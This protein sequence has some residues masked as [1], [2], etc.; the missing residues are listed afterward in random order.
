MASH[1]KTDM[2]F[3]HLPRSEALEAAILRRVEHLGQF[4]A[5]LHT[6]RVT[7]EQLQRHAHQGRPFEVR[8]DV[9]L[10]GRELVANRSRHEDVYVALR[11]AF[12]DMSRQLEETVRRRRLGRQYRQTL[13]RAGLDAAS[14]PEPMSPRRFPE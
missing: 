2:V 6:C 3:S 1:P 9:T 14:E 13:R 5:D 8:L 12:A 7:V 10:N 4:C 11:E